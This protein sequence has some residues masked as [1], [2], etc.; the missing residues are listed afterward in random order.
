MNREQVPVGGDH[1]QAALSV[2]NDGGRVALCGAIAEGKIAYDET[3]VDGI[4]HAVDAFLSMMHGDNTGKM[5]V[6]I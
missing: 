5:V 3:V 2:M 1:L 6:R 4:E